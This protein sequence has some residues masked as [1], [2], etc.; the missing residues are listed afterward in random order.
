MPKP[1]QRADVNKFVGGFITEASVLNFPPNAFSDMLNLELSRTGLISRRLG[2]DFEDDYHLNSSPIVLGTADS[3]AYNTFKWEAVA[4][5]PDK[6]YIVVQVG[7]VLSFYNA[8]NA[9]ISGPGADATLN[10]TQFDPAVR[11]SFASVEGY[12]VA[13]AGAQQIAVVSRDPTSGV[14][15]YEVVRLLVRDVWGVQETIQTQYETDPT[16]RSKVLDNLHYYNLQNQSWGIPRND[17]TGGSVDPVLAYS[18]NG[19]YYPSS[20]EQVW[21]ALQQQPVA[22]GQPPFERLYPTLW[23]DALG[24]SL[25]SA[26][27]YFIIDALNRGASR[28]AAQLANSVKYPQLGH[29][30][31]PPTDSTPAGA[32][33]VTDFAGRI[34]YSGFNGSTVGA[35][36]RS[37]NLANYV[38]FSQ[39]VKSKREFPLCY[40]DGD[41][42]SRDSNDLVDTD[43]GFIHISGARNIIALR[44]LQTHLVVIASNGV[45]TITGGSVDSGFSATNYKVSKISTFG[46]IGEANIVTEGTTCY[47]WSDEGIFQVAKNQYGDMEVQ[48]IT[49]ASV[50]SFYDDIDAASKRS[51]FGEYD[52]IDKKIRWIYK[53]GTLFTSD[54]ATYELILDVALSAFTKNQFMNQAGNNTEVV[55]VVQ[56]AN[57]VTNDVIDDVFVVGDNVVVNVSDQ[58]VVSNV[59][60]ANQAKAI[61]YFTLVNTAGVIT[62]TFSLYKDPTWHDW[63]SYDNIGTDAKA[64]GLCGAIT[65]GDSAVNKQTPYIVMHFVRTEDGVGNDFLP[66][67]PSSCLMQ[68]RWG[69]S[70]QNISNK[71]SPLTQ[72][73]RYTKFRATENLSDIFDTGFGVI[74]TKNKTRGRGRA[75]QLYFET[76]ASHDLQIL[77]WNI[78]LNGNQFA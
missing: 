73:Y 47:F 52:P 24:A 28:I 33:C 25:K 27:G 66:L 55:G 37:P 41:P 34:F 21:P 78:T 71:W 39:L 12:L 17:S 76:E 20:A 22:I 35:D 77:G 29:T 57:F 32:K 44:N 72:A 74:T 26:K 7:N 59:S 13:V 70:D 1:G 67:H 8:T 53:T 10:I 68:T 56:T 61:R 31:V 45:W 48:S 38:F 9:S 42:T 46:G 60:A 64:F 4:G 51:A 16:Y 43:G 63:K 50:Q 75:V 54:S 69:F 3:L 18:T 6:N 14:V 40:Q 62:T 65:A 11:M 49:L 30:V 5:D 15:S 23:I 58:V 36:S 2:I 19:G